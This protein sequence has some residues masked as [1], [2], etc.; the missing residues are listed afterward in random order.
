MYRILAGAF[1]LSIGGAL[2]APVAAQ[3]ARAAA[4]AYVEKAGAGDLYEIRASE[5]ALKKAAAPAVRDFAKTMIA[6]HDESTRAVIAAARSTGLEPKPPSLEPQQET[7]LGALQPLSGTA[8][9]TVYLSQQRIAHQ[10]A[11]T[12]HSDFARSGENPALRRAAADIASVV[13]RHI[14]MLAKLSS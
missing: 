5:L 3:S 12:L 11:L 1:L 14:A 6:Q 8:F 13:E 4:M 2:P 7:M 10:Q 9:D